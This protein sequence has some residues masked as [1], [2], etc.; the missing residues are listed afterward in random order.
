MEVEARLAELRDLD[1]TTK[2]ELQRKLLE[3]QADVL[4]AISTRQ[5]V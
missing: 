3:L 5:V 4:V 2:P 1:E